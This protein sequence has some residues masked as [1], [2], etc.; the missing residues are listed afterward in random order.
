[1]KLNF[2]PALAAAALIITGACAHGS[3]TTAGNDTNATTASGASTSG[4]PTTPGTS[5]AATSSPSAQAGV[6]GGTSN[7]GATVVTDGKEKPSQSAM[8]GSA[9]DSSGMAQSGTT[10]DKVGTPSNAPSAMQPGSTAPT[11]DGMSGTTASAGT[12]ATTDS[13]TPG[14]GS[15]DK[16]SSAAMDSSKPMD[17]NKAPSATTDSSTAMNDSSMNSDANLRS[18]T[19]S[20]S[21]IDAQ[22]QSITLDQT[23]G[24]TL[25][26]TVDSST[27]V[28][29][30]GKPL[31]GIQSLREGQKIRA[32]FDPASNK[33]SKIEIVGARH[34]HHA[35]TMS[36][37]D[38]AGTADQST[39]GGAGDT[40]P[41]NNN[42]GV[43]GSTTDQNDGKIVPKDDAKMKTDTDSGK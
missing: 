16:G 13:A 41:A 4:T 8:K 31:L 42:A 27:K 15:M 7:G 25:T 3:G 18:V 5:Q 11:T 9:G 36:P 35:K 10:T 37:D 26:L 30:H 22:G 23:A 2:G 43:K 24:S 6:A 20:V 40:G 12:T 19:G 34:G 39:T 28:L 32:S 1:M 14:S 21:K 29:R 33:A 38:G 17:M